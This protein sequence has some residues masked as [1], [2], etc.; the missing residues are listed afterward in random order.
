MASLQFVPSHFLRVCQ[1]NNIPRGGA[2]Y[3]VRVLYSTV[4]YVHNLTLVFSMAARMQ[5]A[6]RRR[7]VTTARPLQ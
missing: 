2:C 7:Q 4:Q 6:P 3:S 1:S 5:V